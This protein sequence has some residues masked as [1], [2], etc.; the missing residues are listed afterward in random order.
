VVN[1]RV[2]SLAMKACVEPALSRLIRSVTVGRSRNQYL[3]L[4][5]MRRR[6]AMTGLDASIADKA[7]VG[8]STAVF[9]NVSRPA[10]LKM[11]SCHTAR[12][13]QISLR[14]VLVGR[15]HSVT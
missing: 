2:N 1:T 15:H 13:H 3:A 11:K 5:E 7:A 14:I 8:I 12:N 10:I 4:S 6:K 9:T